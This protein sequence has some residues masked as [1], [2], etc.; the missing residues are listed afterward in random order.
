LVDQ[1]PGL[2][3]RRTHHALD[4]IG[5]KLFHHVDGIVDEEFLDADFGKNTL[6]TTAKSIKKVI[7]G[8]ASQ[9]LFS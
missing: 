4:D 5:G 2:G 6:M 7:N 3:C 8:D 9:G 1:R